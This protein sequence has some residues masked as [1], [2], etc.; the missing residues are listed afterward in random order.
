LQ[1]TK[2]CLKNRT[3]DRTSET[4]RTRGPLFLLVKIMTI[5]SLSKQK[6]ELYPLRLQA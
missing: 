2:Q 3:K 4:S 1:H 5:L 6:F